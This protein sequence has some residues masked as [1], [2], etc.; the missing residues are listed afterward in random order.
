MQIKVQG[1]PDEALKNHSV[2]SL[3]EWI[4]ARKELLIKEKD[5]T[6]LGDKL[7]A[8][9]RELQASDHAD[10]GRAKAIRCE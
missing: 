9:R 8:E 2:V 1:V 10:R 4:A 6:R 7:N 5:L 3:E